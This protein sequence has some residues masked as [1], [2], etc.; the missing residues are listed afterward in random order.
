MRSLR[1][2]DFLISVSRTYFFV[3]AAE[4]NRLAGKDAVV[5]G[6]SERLVRRRVS[7]RLWTLLVIVSSGGAILAEEHLDPLAVWQR[8]GQAILEKHCTRCH[9]GVRRQGNLDLRSLTRILGGGNQQVDLIP[10]SPQDSLVYLYAL[11]DS[12]THMPPEPGKQLSPEELQ[13]LERAIAALPAV[14]KLNP[15]IS[16]DNAIWPRT[17]VAVLEQIRPREWTPPAGMA[18]HDVIDGFIFRRLEQDHISPARPCADPVFVRRVYLDVAGRIPSVTEE[19]EFLA[20]TNPDKRER[21]ID[22]LLASADH[23]Q[24]MSVV[25]DGWLME[26][27]SRDV[28]RQRLKQGWN[29]WLERCVREN[30]PWNAVV[31]DLIVARPESND[32]RGSVAFLLDRKDNFQGMA[33][34]VAPVVFGA[35]MDCAQCHDHPLASEIEQRHYWALV[36]AFNRSKP[37][38][39]KSGRGMAESATGGFISF[40]NLQ[41]ETQPALLAFVNGSTI[42]EHR[43][44]A[45]EKEED[46]PDLYVIPPAGEKEKP[47]RPATPKF[48][49]RAELARVA[50]EGNPLLARACVNR[51]WALY[52]GRGLVHP[53]D[54][55]DTKHPASH[56]ELLDW[57]A[58]DFAA[59]GFDLRRLTRELLLSATYQ[60]DSRWTEA[61]PPLP[62]TFARAIERPLSG[63]QFFAS[64]MTATGT[65]PTAEGQFAGRPID[66]VRWECVL[67]FPDVQSPEYNASVG[68]AL[69][70]SN[71]PLIDSV[72]KPVDGNTMARLI[73]IDDPTARVT[74][75]F[76]TV[77]GRQPDPEELSN[78]IVYLERRE[79]TV[80][81]RQLMWSLVTS[82][83]FLVNH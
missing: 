33:E 32:D 35:K 24:R 10:G 1:S 63:P 83:E 20:D 29:D 81:V 53:A 52:L 27:K 11:P 25:L 34:A 43:P 23:A 14:E 21:L 70:L 76:R 61:N 69:F 79:R 65:V 26:R 55:I 72:L 22:R 46:K 28:D 45:N 77:L 78:L 9:G 15:R 2:A 18:P 39:T 5:A 48:S 68:Q 67:R 42:D 41:K 56:P 64:L 17:Y 7:V 37:V 13:T 59:H 36:S 31:R 19:E 60:R 75:A 16:T 57:L 49:R 47:E 6:L 38:D 50:T 58:S 80:G 4:M 3:A 54:Q 73:A 82:A 8:D 44:A 71:S 12:D 40:A 51:V 30:R 66:D 74:A 62:E